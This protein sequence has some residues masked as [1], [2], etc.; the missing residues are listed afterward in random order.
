MLRKGKPVPRSRVTAAALIALSAA[1]LTIPS[2]AY[3]HDGDTAPATSTAGSA[4]AGWAYNSA[5]L[6]DLQTAEV[7]PF[8]GA[9]ATAAMVAYNSSV[10]VLQVKGI[11]KTA[12]G[13]KYGAHLHAGPCVAGDGAAAGPHY[14]T[15][16]IAGISPPVVNTSTEVWL[17]LTVTAKGQG[18]STATVP[19]VPLPGERSIVIHADPTAP[20]GTAGPR[21]ACLPLIIN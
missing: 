6:R 4:R 5:P 13:G 12:V 10:F 21:L 8:D 14:N 15:D 3:A 11:G 16:L 19:F 1:A 20:N 9:K 17:D 18:L 2:T 7:G